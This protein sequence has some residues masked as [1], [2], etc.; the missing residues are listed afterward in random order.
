MPQFDFFIWFSLSLWTIFIFQILYYFSLYF[1]ISP[2]S[3]IQKTLIKLHLLQIFF[4]NKKK[5]YNLIILNS[6][7]K[8]IYII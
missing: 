2:F 1:I 4:S 8:K 5:N 3:N 6:I 7:F